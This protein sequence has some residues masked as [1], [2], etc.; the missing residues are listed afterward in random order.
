[1]A[2]RR[3]LTLYLSDE[4]RGQ[5]EELRKVFGASTHA[6]TLRAAVRYALKRMNNPRAERTLLDES[7]RWGSDLKFLNDAERSGLE[8]LKREREAL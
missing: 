1:M 5:V 4:E 7:L 6:K 3:K 2:K 8:R